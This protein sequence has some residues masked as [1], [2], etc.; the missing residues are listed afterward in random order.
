M[1]G[2]LG[3]LGTLRTVL[4]TLPLFYVITLTMGLVVQ[5]IIPFDRGGRVQDRFARLWA[6]L[7][8]AVS[9]ARVR[10]VGSERLE[11]ERHYVYVANHS[12]YFDILA[13]L[14]GLPVGV[15]FM[16]KASLFPIPFVGWYL[17]RTGHMPIDLR[18]ASVQANAR[19]L[20]R[21]VG[22]IR[23]GRSL[24]VFPEGGRTA[25]GEMGEFKVG[26][27]LAASRAGIPVVPVAI[28]GSARVLPHSSWA[29][30]PGTVTLF[31]SPPM[32]AAGE[33]REG[34]DQF[35]ADVR[36]RIGQSLQEVQG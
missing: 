35:V 9:L 13:L 26:I 4:F 19:Q 11:G 20:L 1:S 22:L 29:I 16:A 21:A 17:R 2:L 18:E 25:T 15:R 10:V 3:F 12:S 32:E 24:I 6:R 31:F 28:A 33:G 34:L 23:Q 36:A 14:V 27:F 8:L 7:L 5:A 30:R